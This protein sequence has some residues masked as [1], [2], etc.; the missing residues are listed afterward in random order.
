MNKLKEV[1]VILWL[2]HFFSGYKT[3]HNDEHLMNTVVVKMLVKHFHVEFI[4]EAPNGNIQIDLLFKERR[5]GFY[6]KSITKSGTK[7]SLVD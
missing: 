1:Q 3:K 2:T 7:H 4:N 6:Y 5:G